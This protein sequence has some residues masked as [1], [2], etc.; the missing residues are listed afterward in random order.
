MIHI[1]VRAAPARDGRSRDPE[2]VM[3]I[4]ALAERPT[5]ETVTVHSGGASL[6]L[7]FAILW[8]E[9][10]LWAYGAICSEAKGLFDHCPLCLP[11][12]VLALISLAGGLRLFQL[13]RRG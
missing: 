7:W 6:A 2:T 3:K 9:A 4:R 11:A 13:S 12:A 10:P 8:N 5:L 1:K